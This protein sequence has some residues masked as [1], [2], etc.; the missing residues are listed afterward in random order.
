MVRLRCLGDVS[1]DDMC[2]RG[3]LNLSSTSYPDHG[4]CGNLPMPRNISTVELVIEPGT[5][6]LVVRSP[7]LKEYKVRYIIY[8]KTTVV[9]SFII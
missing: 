9:G 4:L 7:D 3:V 6:W 5:S 2:E 1:D 8:F